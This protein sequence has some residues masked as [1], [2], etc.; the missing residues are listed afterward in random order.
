MPLQVG[1]IMLSGDRGQIALGKARMKQAGF[2]ECLGA[3]IIVEFG[4]IILYPDSARLCVRC[5]DLIA[6]S[7]KEDTPHICPKCT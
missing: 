5:S 7:P 6:H 4:K 2:D 1:K 3:H